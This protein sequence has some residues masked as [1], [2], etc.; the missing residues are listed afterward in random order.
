MGLSAKNVWANSKRGGGGI[1]I[2][3]K[4]WWLWGQA[5]QGE[6]QMLDASRKNVYSLGWV[7]Q[8]N[9]GTPKP[10]MKHLSIKKKKKSHLYAALMKLNWEQWVYFW[11]PC[12]QKSLGEVSKDVKKRAP[13]QLDNQG[14]TL[15]EGW[16]F[17]LS[18]S[19]ERWLRNDLID[20]SFFHSKGGKILGI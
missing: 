4:K 19:S 16:E 13:N 8:R 6:V 15:V 11:H 7:L 10:S 18:S 5:G 14:V 12:Y 17:N 20:S 3:K 2:L 9:P 1:C